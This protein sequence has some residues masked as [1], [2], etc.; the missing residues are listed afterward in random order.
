[1]DL[2]SDGRSLFQAESA[3]TAVVVTE[4]PHRP[5]PLTTRTTPAPG[6][7]MGERIAVSPLGSIAVV[8]RIGSGPLQDQAYACRLGQ[9]W[10]PLGP[11]AKRQAV[12]WIGGEFLCA[13][14]GP[15]G[16]DLV[17]QTLD[18]EIRAT[19]PANT[20]QGILGYDA[21]DGRWV[22]ESQAV[23]QVGR[24]Q[25]I[26]AVRL[27][28]ANGLIVACGQVTNPDRIVIASFDGSIAFNA[29]PQINTPVFTAVGSL[30]ACVVLENKRATLKTFAPPYPTVDLPAPP[31]PPPPPGPEPGMPLDPK[32]L[33]MDVQAIVDGLYERNKD[34]AHS[35]NDD[36]RRKL[37]KKI[38][39]TARAR[40]GPR[41]GW[42]SN[43][44]V[45]VANAKDAIAEIP[46]GD[47][48]SLNKRQRLYMWDLFNGTTRLPNR[49]PTSETKHQEQYFVP[50]DPIDH[51]A[52]VPEPPEPEPPGPE[53]PPLPPP[54]PP[55]PVPPA[56]SYDQFVKVEAQ[57]VYDRYVAVH[58]RA[59][60]PADL[61]H[62]AYRRTVERRTHEAIL[63]D[64]GK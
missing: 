34:L 45:G 60:A 15:G 55:A 1:M 17:V 54:P 26:K 43:H 21:I 61:Y 27:R 19:G 12:A 2:A 20:S 47:L 63:A 4:D 5:F 13:R 11:S 39:E 16:R 44:G 24:Y 7:L 35:K 46:E 9:P 51:L 48:L 22:I 58:G 53:P 49:F 6:P 40:K 57:Q 33:P 56:V 59:P 10:I 32:R 50:V 31:P 14:V 25:M 64:I 30:L 36:D 42:K 29:G 18:G 8:A 38:A 62:N 41:W 52:D 23:T 28:L 37:A 3:G